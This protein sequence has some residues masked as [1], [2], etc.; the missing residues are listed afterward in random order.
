[1]NYASIIPSHSIAVW[2]LDHIDSLLDAIGLEK[3]QTIE[4]I[5]Y[6][7]LI[8][9]V[10]LGIGWL[11][12]RATLW[13]SQKVAKARKSDLTR[14]LLAQHTL[15]KCS[16]V[17]PPL[18]FL[19]LA[20]FAFDSSSG[21]LTIIIRSA[22]VLVCLTLA[23]S[24]TAIVTFLFTRYNKRANT[25]N[26]PINGILAVLNGLI[27]ILAIIVAVSIVVQKS[28]A[29][30]LGGMTAFAAV[31]MLIF[32]D[33]ILGLV[34]G[35]QMSQNDMLRVGDWIVVPD[36][37]ANGVVIDVTLTTVKVQNFD[38][39]IV[40]VPPYKLVSAS[41][42]N[43]RGMSD[44]GVRRIAQAVHI[45]PDSVAA[46]EPEQI[47]AL[48]ERFPI[49]KPFVDGL[50][51]ANK[52]IA[53]SPGVS[54]VNGT[55]ETNLG[56]YRAYMTSYLVA[57]EMIDHTRD[58]MLYAGPMSPEGIPVNIYCFSVTTQWEAYEAVLS[59][60]MEHAVLAAGWFGL[61]VL[62]ADH[63]EVDMPA[64]KPL[65]PAPAKA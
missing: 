1:M 44:S 38:N 43:W 13:I 27:W 64:P 30:L 20:P 18:V 37:P 47:E 23:Y 45:N 36:T 54:P 32:K 15:T 22:L 19:S 21:A 42:Q 7:T 55:I 62:S 56:L 17:I 46:P 57:S 26:L 39:T 60:V 51:S 35:V 10:S 58:L 59:A 24:L 50:Q 25:K 48:V 6:F 12:Q 5:I 11:L 41:F 40:M 4:Q 3:H 49:L 8:V 65:A 29:A 28:P 53:W 14:E 31:L 61:E 9:S 16:Y 2:L 52:T 34:S 63:L 33:S